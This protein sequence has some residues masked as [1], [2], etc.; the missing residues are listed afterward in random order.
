MF[1]EKRER[2][3]STKFYLVHSFREAGKVIKIRRFLGTN[4][5]K[6]ELATKRKKAEHFIKEQIKHYEIIG[7]PLKQVLSDKEIKL[8]Q[9]YQKQAIIKVHHLDERDWKRFSEVFSYDTNAIEGSTVT[10]NEVINLIEKNKIPNK[11][12]EDIAEAR[13]VAEAVLYL[14]KAKDH[15]SL[16]LIKK[17]HYIVFK[18][19][20]SF[21]G[22][23]RRKG[24]EVVV[25]DGLGNVVHTGAPSHKVSFLLEELIQWYNKNKNKYPPILLAAVVHN[26]FENI[27][28][29]QDGNGRVGR[30]LLN[31]VLI[32]HG[33]PPVNIHYKNRI[34]YYHTLQE[35][36]NKNNI[37]PTIE[38][39]LK[40]Y[41]K[42]KNDLKR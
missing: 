8:L 2:G 9:T 28:P 12:A 5:T 13:N 27:H 21:A 3:K 1:V 34:E 22:K 26:Q 24:V 29:F 19:S 25:R 35:F 39:I 40:E 11:S 16:R 15:V 20:K 4:L 6:T 23:F 33:L 17:L 14:R 32:K 7:N 38:L 41:K 42:L 30:L 31:N 37:K 10:K 18:E 36:E